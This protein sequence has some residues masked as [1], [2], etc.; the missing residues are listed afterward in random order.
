MVRTA[1]RTMPRDKSTARLPE[2]EAV[3]AAFATD[4]GWM[5]VA[6]ADAVVCGI[7]FGYATQRQ[8]IDSLWRHLGRRGTSFFDVLAID[9]QPQEIADLIERLTA[10]AAGAPVD[11]GSVRVDER[12]LTDFGRRIVKAVELSGVAGLLFRRNSQ[13]GAVEVLPRSGD[14]VAL[15]AAL[16][17]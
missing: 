8:A 11:F 7:V 13:S 1:I 12:H 16:H 4:L 14:G 10:Y 9:E 5:A 3:A 17:A 6:H 2:N 15:N